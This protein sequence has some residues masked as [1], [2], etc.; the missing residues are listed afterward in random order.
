MEVEAAAPK[1][2][3]SLTPGGGGDCPPLK[4]KK[5]NPEAIPPARASEGAAG[6]DL[7]AAEDT[8]IVPGT[9]K[10][11][12]T[13][14]AVQVPPL[15]YGRVAPRSGLAFKFG[16]DI[17][18]GVIDSDYRGPLGIVM[19]NNGVA[20]FEVKK[21]QRIAQF[22]IERV[23][24]PEVQVVDELDDSVRGAKGFGSTGMEK[25]PLPADASAELS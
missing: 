22:L 7:C 10:V 14:L 24:V 9:R 23:D 17:G 6:Y 13:G 18:A 11:V 2:P 20:D 1:R 8:T 15:H 16:I 19:V 21:G 4:V 3:P 12:K 5:L 25:L